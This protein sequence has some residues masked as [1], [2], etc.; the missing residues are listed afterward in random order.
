MK[1]LK[2]VTKDIKPNYIAALTLFLILLLTKTMPASAQRGPGI[3]NVQQLKGRLIAGPLAEF[4]VRTAIVSYHDGFIV[5][6]IEDAGSAGGSSF[7]SN[8][9]DVSN[10]STPRKTVI[11]F[12]TPNSFAGAHGFFQEGRGLNLKSG[13]TLYFQDTDGDGIFDNAAEATS[14]QFRSIFNLPIGFNPWPGKGYIYQPFGLSA[15]FYGDD[16]A[17]ARFGLRDSQ[18]GSAWTVRVRGL[19]TLLGNTAFYLGHTDNAAPR[20]IEVFDLSPVLQAQPSGG[21]TLV[22]SV[23]DAE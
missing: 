3:P 18:L 16:G 5:T 22:S 7:E 6:H 12:L 9:Y 15:W 20:G 11:P 17:Q 2:F 19:P 8:F 10:L 13:S 4:A 21:I 14:G 1:F 23:I